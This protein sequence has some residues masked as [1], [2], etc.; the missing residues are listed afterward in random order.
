MNVNLDSFLFVTSEK[1]RLLLVKLVNLE[2]VN[3]IKMHYR[4]EDLIVLSQHSGHSKDTDLFKCLAT[5]LRLQKKSV[6]FACGQNDSRQIM[7]E[8]VGKIA[9]LT[10]LPRLEGKRVAKIVGG[11]FHSA[12]LTHDGEVIES[13]TYT[14]NVA[15]SDN[16]NYFR[17]RRIV[18]I[19]AGGACHHLLALS[20]L[21][22]CSPTFNNHAASGSVYSVGLNDV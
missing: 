22:F 10:R 3:S 12:V 6:V 15:V 17:V 1:K 7:N 18:D 13:G 14:N 4:F 19:A 2:L 16:T 5:R 20:G 8:N 9:T 21:L 11:Y